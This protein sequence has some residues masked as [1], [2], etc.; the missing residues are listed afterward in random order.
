MSAPLFSIIVTTRNE[1]ANLE[2]CLKSLRGQSYFNTEI[3][4]VDNNSTDSTKGIANRYTDLVF[5]LG[6]ERSAQRNFGMLEVAKGKFVMYVDADMILTPDLIKMAVHQL[7]NSTIA[8]LYVPEVVLGKT[9]FARIR[10]FERQFY[11]ATVIDAARI[12]RKDLLLLSGGF[13]EVLFERGSGEDWDLDKRIRQLGSVRMLQESSVIRSASEIEIILKNQ[14]VQIRANWQ[15]ILHNESQDRLIPYLKKKR[16][17]SS[18]FSGY[19]NKWG[20]QD[21]DIQRQFGIKYRLFQVFTE[22]NKWKTSLRHPIKIAM[23]I[24]LKILVALSSMGKWR[25]EYKN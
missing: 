3:I 15:G 8:A 23:V 1:E 13:D 7:E 5:N 12:F 18:G 16:Y 2:A 6:P 22:N 14:G 25:S 20:N 17:Y 9:L 11:D 21:S 19:I 24:A 4:V 10:R